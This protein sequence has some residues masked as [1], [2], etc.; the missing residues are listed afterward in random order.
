MEESPRPLKNNASSMF[1]YY[2]EREKYV[3]EYQ[4]AIEAKAL[5]RSRLAECFRVE[6]VN[7]IENC[8][9]LRDKYFALCMDRFNGMIFPEGAEPANRAVMGIFR[10]EDA[11]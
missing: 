4:I 6:G 7:H 2:V 8:K 9:E 5:V 3:R 10:K 1:D 11:P